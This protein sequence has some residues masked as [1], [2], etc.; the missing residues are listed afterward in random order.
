MTLISFW[1]HLVSLYSSCPRIPRVPSVLVFLVFLVPLCSTCSSVPHV[2]SEV[3][4]S[5][6]DRQPRVQTHPKTA[7]KIATRDSRCCLRAS[8]RQGGL[9]GLVILFRVVGFNE[10]NFSV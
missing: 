4:V 6:G 9:V 2:V 1:L 7:L 10:I 3:L 8:G 5:F